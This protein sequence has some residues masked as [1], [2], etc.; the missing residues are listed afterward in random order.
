MTDAVIPNGERKLFSID[1]FLTICHDFYLN[2]PAFYL[3]VEDILTN[4]PSF[5]RNVPSF[6]LNVPTFY[7]NVPS[8]YRNVPSFLLDVPTFLLR[9]DDIWTIFRHTMI[10]IH[11]FFFGLHTLMIMG[12]SFEYLFQ[13]RLP[14]DGSR[15]IDEI[16]KH[17][18]NNQCKDC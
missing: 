10:N 7:R 9:R 17:R 15:G 6:Y 14:H 4:V 18:N 5:Y 13:E 11:L 12:S 2:V 8:F 3:N 16:I 1:D